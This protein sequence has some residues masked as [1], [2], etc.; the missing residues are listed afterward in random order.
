MSGSSGTASSLG[1]TVAATARIHSNVSPAL[2][3]GPFAAWFDRGY[4]ALC[5]YVEREGHARVPASH[6]EGN[7]PL[8]CWVS[9]RR[10][11]YRAG[12]LRA[13]YAAVLAVLP[14][15]E[16]G[17]DHASI[18]TNAFARG[19]AMALRFV[20]R[21][22]H[23]LIPFAQVELDFALGKWVR[24]QRAAF[25]AHRLSTERIAL[26]EALPCWSWG[27]TLDALSDRYFARGKGHLIQYAVREGHT[28]IPRDYREGRYPLGRWSAARRAKYRAGRLSAG[29]IAELEAVPFWTWDATRKPRSEFEGHLWQYQ[30]Y[31]ARG[32]N[33]IVPQGLRLGSFQVGHWVCTQRDAY[34]AGRLS[35][36]RIT[37]LEAVPGWSW[38]GLDAATDRA[39]AALRVYAARE[40]HCRVP[41]KCRE[42]EFDLGGWVWRRRLD[43][44]LGRLA[45][46]RIAALEQV[47]GWQ[48]TAPR[49]GYLSMGPF[50][51]GLAPLEAF[52]AREG[53]ARVPQQTIEAGFA[54]GTWVRGRRDDYH[55]G[56]LTAEQIAMLDAL[57]GWLWRAPIGRIA[58]PMSATTL[59]RGLGPLHAFVA[60]EG[61]ARV[62]RRAIEDGFAIGQWVGS[63]R[64]DYHAGRLTTEQIAV[65]EALPG[66]SWRLNGGQP[67]A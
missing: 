4:A 12:R 66:W 56:R 17:T 1:R 38:S 39:I 46:D 6:R 50:R 28:R 18:S 51:C 67:R 57:P 13:D 15:W 24:M 45:P 31:V 22:G 40:G 61:H 49:S 35:A 21:E 32:G 27:P 59:A 5:V 8:G 7:H 64:L 54:L 25:R 52:V 33:P 55:A 42:G 62:P 34:H 29:R 60:R 65:L 3:S 11:A 37:A 53:H 19:Y 36:E 63:R 2:R 16:W 20:T 41:A 48:W 58:R 44:R 10:M 26:L 14:G 9:L 47:P 23:A 30:R 43:Y